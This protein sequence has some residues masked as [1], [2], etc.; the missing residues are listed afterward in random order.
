MN[1]LLTGGAG[2]IG[3]HTIIELD[4]A[5][6]SVVVIDNFSNSNNQALARVESMIGKKIPF[7]E[8]DVR[9]RACLDRIFTENSID[10]VIHFAGFKAVGE[11]VRKPIEYYHNNMTAT[12][13]LVEA[14]RDH[15]CKNLIFS[16]SCTVYGAPESVPVN[17]TCKAGACTNP[18]GRTKA[19]LEN[20]LTDLQIA[21]PEWNIALL[22]YFNPVGAHPCGK[23][24]EDPN[25]IPNCLMPY[26]TKVA[27]GK[28]PKLTVF[29][30]DYDTPDGTCIR[31]YIHVCD[32]ASGHV[33]A[34][35]A[36]AAGCGL[37][38]YNLSTGRG[39]SVKE[40][41][42]SFVRVNGVDVPYAIG[43]RRSGDAPVMFGDPSKIKHDLGW[44]AVFGLDD[45]CRDAYN[46]QKNNPNGYL[47]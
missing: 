36:I 28:L 23:I 43:P 8:A 1:I 31:D 10:A 13:I 41:I 47:E 46:F 35:K 40:V 39:H 34:L 37:V 6:H 38:T 33:A 45:M 17:E 29:G 5:G 16:S 42:D 25:G 15:G 12:F 14:M 32:V 19:M 24:G 2:Y 22:R 20:V 7:Y 18:Y 3:T 4:K 27:V 11:S 26:I 30:D 9:D 21:E 44:E